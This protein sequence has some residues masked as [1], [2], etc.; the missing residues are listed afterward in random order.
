V[1]QWIMLLLQ[2][3][4]ECGAL[5]EHR[6]RALDPALEM[7]VAAFHGMDKIDKMQVRYD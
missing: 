7:L 4:V 5:A 1:I 2:K 3:E 6:L